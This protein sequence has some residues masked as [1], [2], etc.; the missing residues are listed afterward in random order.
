M[1]MKALSTLSLEQLRRAVAIKE[2][3]VAL[4]ADLARILGTPAPVTAV[5]KRRRK[6]KMT[7]PARATILAASIAKG[8]KTAATSTKK[9]KRKMSEKARAKLSA[10][11]KARWAKVKEAGKKSLGK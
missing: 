4:E 2:K 11:A 7:A 1:A 10:A 6:T 5:V 9:R 3:I 8:N